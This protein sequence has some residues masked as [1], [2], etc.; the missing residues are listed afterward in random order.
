MTDDAY[1]PEREVLGS[2]LSGADIPAD[3]DAGMFAS[4][5]NRIIFNAL[6]RLKPECAPD[7][8]ILVNYL[9]ETGELDT[10]G[11]P[12]Y[13][14]ELTSMVPGSGNVQYYRDQLREKNRTRKTGMAIRRAAEKARAGTLAEEDKQALVETLSGQG[15]GPGGRKTAWTA[16]ELLDHEFPPVKWIVQDLVSTGLTILAGAPKLG[17]SWLAMNMSLGVSSGGSVLGKIPVEKTGVM[18]LALEDTGRRLQ[19]RLK[20]LN[21]SRLDNL[22]FFTEWTGKT[23]GLAAYL[24]QHRDIRLVVIDTWGRFTIPLIKDH[25]SYSE[26]TKCAAELKA[27]ADE[28]DIAILLITH[29]RKGSTSG[30]DW[31]DGVLGSQGLSGAADSTIVLRRSRGNRQADLQATGRDITEKELVLSFDVD[32][33][34]WSIEGA[35]A[36]IQESA[37]RQGIFDWLKDNGPH[38]PK[39]IYD[40]MK[41]EGA[42][43]SLSTVKT[44]LRKM[45]DDGALVNNSGMYL[46]PISDVSD[47]NGENMVKSNGETLP[48]VTNN[49]TGKPEA[50]PASSGT[51]APA[52]ELFREDAPAVKNPRPFS[53]AVL[54]DLETSTGPPFVPPGSFAAPLSSPEPAEMD[55]W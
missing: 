10:A 45:V 12:A 42:E 29:T 49:V 14:A 27:I 52:S 9:K 55:I 43:R 33:G 24:R 54:P 48:T 2:I 30:S 36:D 51:P 16:A 28:L 1:F 35:K 6:R 22:H 47:G 46:V 19:E 21:A 26:T 50:S 18:Y 23:A 13:I 31:I 8:V 39:Q 20:R 34:E 15:T 53:T 37:A 40:G 11:G 7:L 5:R 3:I 38:T 4:G 32:A 25:N 17:K 41:E 44:L